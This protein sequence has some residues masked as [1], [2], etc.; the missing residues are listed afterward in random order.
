MKYTLIIPSAG[1]G[2]RT[3]NYAKHINKALI[4]VGGKPAICHIID[5]MRPLIKKVVIALGYKGDILRQV[6][7]QFYKNEPQLIQFVDIDNYQGQG[8]GLGYTLFKCEHLLNTPFI[9]SSNDTI[10]DITKYF[11]Q[12]R[13]NNDILFY[14]DK[15]NNIEQYRTLTVLD[16]KVLSINYKMNEYELKRLKQYELIYPY[17]GICVVNDYKKFWQNMHRDYQ[18]S[19]ITGEVSGFELNSGMF[20]YKVDSW[21]DI[22]SIE[23]IQKTQQAFQLKDKN[24]L[25]KQNEGIWFTEDKRVIKF[26]VD[27]QFISERLYRWERLTQQK[28]SKKLFPKI[29]NH[30]EHTYTYEELDGLIMSNISSVNKFQKILKKVKEELWDINSYRCWDELLEHQKESINEFYRQKTLQRVNKFLAKYEIHNEK[31]QIINDVQMEGVYKLIQNIDFDRIYEG[32]KYTPMFHGDYHMQNILIDK[33]DV[34][35]LDWRQNFGSSNQV[36]GDIQYDLAKFKQSLIVSHQIIKNDLYDVQFQGQR[37]YYNILIPS[38]YREFEKIFD[39]FVIQNDYDPYSIDILTSLVFLNI[40]CLHSPDKYAMFLFLL[41]KSLLNAA[42]QR[43]RQLDNTVP[44]CNDDVG[45]GH[46]HGFNIQS[47]EEIK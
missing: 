1:I 20:A 2:S 33:D 27:R 21:Y 16:D 15:I 12:L 13:S 18:L 3:E 30:T 25:P 42:I 46:I 28:I 23:N 17:I 37:S 43:E 32:G 4:T 38:K 29:I 34:Y 26:N 45:H 31:K 36:A 10:A 9:F 11:P 8:S 14:Y 22:G 19:I 41:G 44:S 24:I 5:N 6:L 39:F 7:Q 47:Y 35:L 40:A